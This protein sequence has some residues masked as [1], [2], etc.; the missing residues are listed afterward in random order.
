MWKWSRLENVRNREFQLVK[1]PVMIRRRKRGMW[2][3]YLPTEM[4][5]FRPSM[6]QLT[7]SW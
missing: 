1:M 6:I 4:V 7:L 5:F 3:V 2:L